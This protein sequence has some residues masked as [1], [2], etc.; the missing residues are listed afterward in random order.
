MEI[1]IIID[2]DLQDPPEMITELYTKWKEGFEVSMPGAE[3]VR[4]KII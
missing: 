4:W 3:T 2:A 1:A